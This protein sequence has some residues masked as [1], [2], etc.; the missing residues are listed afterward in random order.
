MHEDDVKTRPRTR[1]PGDS[2]VVGPRDLVMPQPRDQALQDQY[3]PTPIRRLQQLLS[4]RLVNRKFCGVIDSTPELQRMTFC[5]PNW[6][7]AELPS[8]MNGRIVMEQQ[9]SSG[10]LVEGKS[11]DEIWAQWMSSE[12]GKGPFLLNPLMARLCDRSTSYSSSHW[13]HGDCFHA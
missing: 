9:R 7:Y 6:D 5:A 11:E 3:T 4:F 10:M 13:R 2:G 8:W 12:A 1:A